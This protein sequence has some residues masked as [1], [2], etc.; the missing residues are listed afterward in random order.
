M[1][2]SYSAAGTTVHGF[3]VLMWP[4]PNPKRLAPK[5]AAPAATVAPRPTTPAAAGLRDARGRARATPDGAVLPSRAVHVRTVTARDLPACLDLFEAVC[6]EGRW[7]ATEAPIDR[8][9]VRARWEALLS[10]GEGT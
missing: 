7:L 10:T 3:G 5:G 9:E 4:Y 2:R 6:A 1:C 8:R